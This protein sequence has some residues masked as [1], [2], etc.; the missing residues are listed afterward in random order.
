MHSDLA[1]HAQGLGRGDYVALL[2][3]RADRATREFFDRREVGEMEGFGWIGLRDIEATSERLTR[4]RVTDAAR[5]LTGKDHGLMQRCLPIQQV[6]QLIE[7]SAGRD[8]HYLSQH[9]FRGR[10]RRASMLSGLSCQHLDLDYYKLT[11]H[12]VRTVL[13]SDDDAVDAI[14]TRCL[15]AGVSA[16]SQIVRS[17]RGLYVKWLFTTF[18]P[19]AAAPRWR[20]VQHALHALFTDFGS[21]PKA[22]DSSRV[23]R[24]VGSWH[25]G[26]GAAVQQIYAGPA[27]TLDELAR[28]C[29]ERERLSPADRAMTRRMREAAVA[30]SSLNR[31]IAGAHRVRAAGYCA[32]VF[33]DL[34]RLI[35][36]RGARNDGHRERTLFWAGNFGLAAGL[37]QPSTL[38]EELADWAQL[39]PRPQ[40][41]VQELRGGCMTSVLKRVHEGRA[42]DK[43]LYWAKRSTLVKELEIDDFELHE[44]ATLG[45]RPA[46]A[47]GSGSAVKQLADRPDSRAVVFE[48]ARAGTPRPEIC[49]ASGLS[50]RQVDR[51]LKSFA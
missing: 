36:M 42:Q 43:G 40:E 1:L 9:R 51:L 45:R 41:L 50:R 30:G 44:L 48:L 37:L 8:Q 35:E 5:G 33:Y 21:D 11:S 7:M 6:G 32:G 31:A 19:A 27:L 3:P 17:G 20:A 13:G 4:S 49:K 22:L 38:L 25:A 29:L 2:F 26:A 34:R 28:G 39:M 23:L 24:V 12:S 46:S 47:A 18:V 10:S 15:D 16:P 14:L